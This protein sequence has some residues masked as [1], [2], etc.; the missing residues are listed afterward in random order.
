MVAV[1]LLSPLA[2]SIGAVI[3]LPDPFEKSFVCA[4]DE[5]YDR[6]YSTE[7]EKIVVI[8]GSSVAFGLRSDI[9][10]EYAQM[11]VVNFGLYAALGTK[12]MLDL[13]RDAIGEGD[14][15][16]ITPEIDAQTLSLYFNTELTLKAV[17][18]R[19]DMF[20]RLPMDEKLSLISG[21]WN[22]AAQKLEYYRTDSES[23]GADGVYSSVNFNELCDLEYPRSENIMFNYCDPN[24]MINPSPDIVSDDFIDYLNDY[25]AYCRRRGASVYFNGVN[26]LYFSINHIR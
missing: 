15:V 6:L 13:S 22:Y 17:G 9:L 3:L 25:A 12:L 24:N 4:L 7:G 19:A 8:G 21:A 2:I 5:K 1:M 11:P 18:T 10:E 23:G 20:M 26:K 16:I 14:V